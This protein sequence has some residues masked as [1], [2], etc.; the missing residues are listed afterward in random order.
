M[1]HLRIFWPIF[2]SVTLCACD[3]RTVAAPQPAPAGS[4]VSI[5]SIVPT[6]DTVLVPGTSTRFELK[7]AYTLS[8]DSGTIDAVFQDAKG[9][10]LSLTRAKVSKGTGNEDFTVAIKIPETESV[11]LFVPLGAEGQ[12]ATST[13]ATR[14]YKVS[15][16]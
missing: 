4:T 7:V 1:H 10:V 12:T 11:Q 8:V 14:T 3:E 6:T 13:I 9:E 15:K 2:F 5:V 16:R